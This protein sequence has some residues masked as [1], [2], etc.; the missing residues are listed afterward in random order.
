MKKWGVHSFAIPFSRKISGASGVRDKIAGDDH[1]GQ[2]GVKAGQVSVIGH[3][4]A[5]S[6]YSEHQIHSKA[7]TG[8]LR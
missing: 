4:R 1:R 3:L 2:L 7:D 6:G 8:R 5:N